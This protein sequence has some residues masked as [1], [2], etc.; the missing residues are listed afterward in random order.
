MSLITLCC[1]CPEDALILFAGEGCPSN[2]FVV[3][4]DFGQLLKFE[5]IEMCFASFEEPLHAGVDAA[6]LVLHRNLFNASI[7]QFA[8]EVEIV[9]A[10]RPLQLLQ[11]R[12]FADEVEP[13]L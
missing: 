3:S 1:P 5:A 10:V 4:V 8:A 6:L 7:R 11:L 13:V 12:I 2:G 9:F